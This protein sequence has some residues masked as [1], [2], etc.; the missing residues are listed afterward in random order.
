MTALGDT[1]LKPKSFILKVP[2]ALD[3]TFYWCA[4]L[5]NIKTFGN[6]NPINSISFTRLVIGSCFQKQ[7]I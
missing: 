7:D 2:I 5:I 6:I 1:W 3:N 4:C